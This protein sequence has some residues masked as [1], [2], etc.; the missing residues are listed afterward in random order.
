LFPPE[1]GLSSDYFYLNN[2]IEGIPL[3]GGCWTGGS[4]AG[5]FDLILNYDRSNAYSNI[6]FRPA[7]V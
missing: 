3:R 7:F 5:V 1:T 6:G 4:N 2:G